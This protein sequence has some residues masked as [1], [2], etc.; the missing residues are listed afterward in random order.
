M[1]R[2]QIVT[3]GPPSDLI[4]GMGQ[5]GLSLKVAGWNSAAT[6]ALADFQHEFH[7]GQL[8]VEVRN[9]ELQLG[10]VVNRLVDAEVTVEDVHIKRSSL[11]DVFLKLT[12]HTIDDDK[13]P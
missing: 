2:G 12:G 8:S 13:S 6:H 1:D 10:E 3:E 11:E 4:A 9:P 5:Q 7:D